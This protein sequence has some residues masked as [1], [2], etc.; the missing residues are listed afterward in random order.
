[1]LGRDE[2]DGVAEQVAHLDEIP[3]IRA[4]TSRLATDRP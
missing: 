2:A 1:V 3:D 4:L